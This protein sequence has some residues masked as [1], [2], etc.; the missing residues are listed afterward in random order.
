MAGNASPVSDVD[1]FS[2]EVLIDPY[3]FYRVLRDAGPAI[4]LE[5]LDAWALPR[6]MEIRTALKDWRN[7]TSTQGIAFNP[8]QNSNTEGMVITTEGAEHDHLRAVLNERLRLGAV[9]ELATDLDRQ[10]DELVGSL[11]SRGSFDAVRDLARV[12]PGQVVGGLL[13]ISHEVSQKLF[14]WG[15]ASFTSVGPLNDRTNAALPVIAD[16]FAFM[17]GMTNEDFAE[18]SIGRDLYD[19]ADRGHIP[20]D[21]CP[22]MLWNFTGAGADTTMSSLGNAIWLLGR[23]P[24]AWA[25]LREDP[26]LIPA[27]INEVLRFE[28]S[29]Q[30]WGRAT[31]ADWDAGGTVIPA[32][33]RV[34]VLLGSG[35]RDERQFDEPEKFDV[36]RNPREHLSFGYGVHLCVGAALARAQLASVL[37]AL[38]KRVKTFEIGEP[39]R[40]LNNVVRSLKTLPVTV[41]ATDHV[42]GDSLVTT[43]RY[44]TAEFPDIDVVPVLIVGGGPAGLTAALELSRRG[45][46]G[47]LIERRDFDTH[48]PRAHLLNVRTMETFADV[49]VAEQIYAEAPAATEWH[50]VSWYTSLGG[51]TPLHGLKIGEVPAW[52]GGSDAANYEAASPRPFA[53]LPQLRVD[54][55]LAEHADR[56]WPGRVRAQQELVGLHCDAA[57]ATATILDR[58]VGSTYQVRARYVI[59]ADGG[60]MCSDLLGVDVVG[61]RALMDNVSIF[62]SA[63][64]SAVAEPDG[65][66]TFFV[67]PHGQGSY[68]GALLALGP[69]KWGAQSPQWTLARA[70]R[71]GDPAADDEQTLISSLNELLGIP[72]LDIT[73]HSIS[74][75]QFE[76]VVAERFR[77]GPVFL[78]G[79]AAH[80]HPPT[81][82]LGLNTA[83]GDVSNLSWK[84]AAVLN[85]EATE[86]L[87]DSY[88]PERMPVAV[89][90][91]EHSLRNA[92]RHAPIGAAMGLG[93]GMTQ[94]QGWAEIGIWASDTP[95]G[96]R[97]RAA[98]A[99]AVAHNAEDFSQLNIEA[100]FAYSSPAV[101]GDGTPPPPGHDT[102]RAFVSTA[103]P[104][105]HVPHVWLERGGE[106]VS[107]SDLIAA[108]GMTLFVASAHAAV[109]REAARQCSSVITVI[110]I[111]ADLADPH[112][113]WARVSGTDP[114][115]AVLVRPDRHVGWRAASC[116]DDPGQTLQSVLDGLLRPAGATADR[117]ALLLAGLVEAGE[118]LRVG[119]S[120]K[121]VLFEQTLEQHHA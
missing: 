45:I 28:S 61:P 65:L 77:V 82:G 58:Q 98:V 94:E 101:I 59:A 113:Q 88:E 34:A 89:R 110:E 64:L 48:F 75:W 24:Q 57:G 47:M 62:M 31:R 109:W 93:P 52:G 39:T 95:E 40:H 44:A 60:R 83:I 81:G 68:A 56:A 22:Q 17:V 30:I 70:Y 76:G 106:Q 84:I 85:G 55:I 80:R 54:A 50:K 46:Q 8:I 2:D 14:E 13:G 32:G 21:M 71:V 33:S 118:M 36:T 79:D 7:V 86:S 26:S 3:P 91:V 19:A 78:V 1:L 37:G 87:L 15:D 67:N 103:R 11:V 90:N 25:Q 9:R 35:N 97:R 73:V 114:S 74:H 63:D 27:A 23:H 105:H 12:Y 42:K 16:L 66:I 120:R 18:G 107:S 111:G 100:G 104:G 99:E 92:S 10:S 4:Y 72:D 38:L 5:K 20:R 43:P 108:T 116:P 117:P 53:N 49:G 112:G 102:A 115:G 51:P 6:Y 96:E 69:G 41:T 29:I 119:P 121:A